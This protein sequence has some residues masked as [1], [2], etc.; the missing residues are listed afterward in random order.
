MRSLLITCLANLR[1]Y[2]HPN[3]A[4]IIKRLTILL[5]I[6][7][8]ALIINIR[9]VLLNKLFL[10]IFWNEIRHLLLRL[11]NLIIQLRLILR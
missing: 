7:I 6:L 10:L 4:L 2:D 8:V 3:R 5:A 11:I 1:F 9:F